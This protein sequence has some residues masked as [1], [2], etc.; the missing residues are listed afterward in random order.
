LISIQERKEND[1]LIQIINLPQED[2]GIN[3]SSIASMAA[4]SSGDMVSLKL[5]TR[6]FIN[7]G[8]EASNNKQ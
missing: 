1:P 3:M 4:D 6:L 2:G 8:F 5:K 7:E